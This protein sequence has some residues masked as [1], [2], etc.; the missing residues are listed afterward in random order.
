MLQIRPFNT[1]CIKMD[2]DKLEQEE[3]AATVFSYL[4]R[5]L[6]NGN[7]TAVKAELMEKMKPIKELYSLTDDVYPLYIDMCI[8]KRKF[9]K[10]P[11]TMEAFGKALESD[12]VKW[13]D[14]RAMM[15]WIREIQN[16]VRTYGNIKTK[17]R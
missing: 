6:S 15:G 3:T 9:L 11:E 14:E 1:G 4:I 16:Q 8:E 17:R 2:M 5:G 12:N 7:R 13:E 10:V